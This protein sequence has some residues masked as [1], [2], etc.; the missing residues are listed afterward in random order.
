MLA[1]ARDPKAFFSVVAKEPVQVR[2]AD[3]MAFV[4][5]QR[6]PRRGSDKVVQGLAYATV[7]AAWI[8]R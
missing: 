5:A 4:T 6:Q 2:P 8:T 7:P 1:Y 3:V